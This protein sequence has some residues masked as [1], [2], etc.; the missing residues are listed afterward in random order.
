MSDDDDDVL[1]CETCGN[2]DDEESFIAV[3][4]TGTLRCPRCEHTF[5]DPAYDPDPDG[6]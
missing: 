3:R 1:V 4:P 5:I 6:Y 2:R